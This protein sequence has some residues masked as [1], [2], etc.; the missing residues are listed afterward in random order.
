[1]TIRLRLKKKVEQEQPVVGELLDT[2][3]KPG[4]EDFDVAKDAMKEADR[5]TQASCEK[6]GGEFC[7]FLSK[8]PKTKKIS[9]IPTT[10][11]TTV[12]KPVKT[13]R[14]EK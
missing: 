12:S 1:M 5:E 14:K 10:P 13:P 4:D 3:G 6:D 11:S 8:K 9:T 7:Y 2:W